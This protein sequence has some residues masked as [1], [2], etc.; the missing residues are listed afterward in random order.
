M[1]NDSIIICIEITN[2]KN[3]MSFPCQ[4]RNYVI[5]NSVNDFAEFQLEH[6]GSF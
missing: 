3:I 1:E 4:K 2:V 6:A 5:I